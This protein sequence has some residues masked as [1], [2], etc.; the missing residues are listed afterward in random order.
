MRRL[1]QRFIDYV[2]A[3]NAQHRDAHERD[4]ARQR[5]MISL[6]FSAITGWDAWRNPAPPLVEVLVPLLSLAYAVVALAHL[7][8]GL[9]R[10]RAGVASQYLFIVLDSVMTVVAFVG[11]PAMLGP[12]YPVLMVQIVRCGMRYGLR[13]LWLSWAAAALAALALMPLSAYWTGQVLLLRSF[14]AMMV[15]IPLLFAPLVRTLHRVTSE[16][17]IAA[18]SDPLTGLSNR[19]LLD[20]HI[21]LARERCER[22]RSMLAVMLVDLDNF[23][24]VNDT[25]GHAVGDQL[26]ERV[27]LAIQRC[28]RDGDFLARIGGDEFVLLVA[29]LPEPVGRE[30]AKAIADKLV[31][32]VQA[33]ADELVP[34][35]GVSASAGVYCW[36]GG[37]VGAEAVG[38][39][40]ERADRAM[41]LAKR[42]GKARV[43]LAG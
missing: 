26:L 1:L 13:T 33:T 42:A 25:F 20:E 27:A 23:K 34:A 17:R 19:R 15:V 16:L 4:R 10:Q 6:A 3:H 8:L 21:R 22:E 37:V 18:G 5:A 31:S 24:V 2:G 9:S 38:D 40:V 30:R 32:V 12:L 14:V 39:L 35:A 11:A 41:Y 28:C 29:G 7:K 36:T 43:E